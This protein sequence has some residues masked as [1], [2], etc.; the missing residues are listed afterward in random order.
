MIYLFHIPPSGIQSSDGNNGLLPTPSIIWS[1]RYDNARPPG[2]Y[3]GLY[4]NHIGAVLP[5]LYVNNYRYRHI[6]EFG[7]GALTDTERGPCIGYPGVLNHTIIPVSSGSHGSV[8]LQRSKGRK[9]IYLSF[10]P[11]LPYE[12]LLLYTDLL[13]KPDRRGSFHVALGQYKLLG[14]DEEWIRRMDHDEVTG[15]ILFLVGYEVEYGETYDLFL[16]DLPRP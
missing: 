8:D 11:D 7:A 4:Y 2:G 10:Y 1:Y 16:A 15:R 9:S 5:K 6:I 12:E 14:V 3:G 13:D